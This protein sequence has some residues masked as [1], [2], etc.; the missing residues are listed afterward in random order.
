MREKEWV[1]LLVIARDCLTADPALR[2]TADQLAARL[3][4]P[5]SEPEFLLTTCS[6]S[7]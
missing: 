3:H 6:N 4:N 1:G 5:A 7:T 2:P